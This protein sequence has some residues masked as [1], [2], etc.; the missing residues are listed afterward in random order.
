MN[1]NWF[2]WTVPTAIAIGGIFGV[3]ILCTILGLRNRS[4]PTKG[5]LPMETTRG[6]RV[7][8]SFVSLILI[9]LFWVAANLPFPPLMFIPA[10][11]V[12]ILILK[13]G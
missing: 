9:F 1:L 5:F 11:I 10:I 7:F 12:A 6:D 8:L 2:Y 13:R 4:R 3:V